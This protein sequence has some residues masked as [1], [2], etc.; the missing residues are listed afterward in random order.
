MHRNRRNGSVFQ[1]KSVI[2][3]TSRLTNACSSGGGGGG[4]GRSKTRQAVSVLV[5]GRSNPFSV[6]FLVP[7]GL[8]S[9]ILTCTELNWHWRLF[10]LVCYTFFWLHVLD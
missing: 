2:N 7:S 3:S 10:D 8:P 9:R 6:V 1:S 4:Q 5:P